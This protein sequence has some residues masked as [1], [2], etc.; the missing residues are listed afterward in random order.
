MFLAVWPV[1]PGHFWQHKVIS[2]TG[3]CNTSC[4]FSKFFGFIHGMTLAQAFAPTL[5]ALF[6][7]AASISICNGAA[8]LGS[9]ASIALV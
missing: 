7:L 1:S 2:E 6:R 4:F 3:R 8:A 9:V 5:A